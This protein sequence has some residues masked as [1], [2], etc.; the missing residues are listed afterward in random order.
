[1]LDQSKKAET[2]KF[3]PINLTEIF[4]SPLKSNLDVQGILSPL[5]GQDLVKTRNG[6]L[7]LSHYTFSDNNK[8]IPFKIWGPLPRELYDQRYNSS[9][10]KI[11]GVKLSRYN[12]QLQ[13]VLQR[14][15]NVQIL[16]LKQK[17]LHSA[18][19]KLTDT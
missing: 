13:F 18:I 6:K 8:K 1:M 11:K 3:K 12:G 15:G 19:N 4:K 17:N 16:S 9:K 2:E 5:E 10:V 7:I 14:N